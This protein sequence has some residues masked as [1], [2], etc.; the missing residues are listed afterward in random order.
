MNLDEWVNDVEGRVIGD[1]QCVALAQDYSTR[2]AQGGFLSTST[3]PYP[4]YAGNIW[5]SEIAGYTKRSPVSIA[6]PGWIVVWGRS[7][8]TPSTHVAIVL[9]DAGVGVNTMTQNPGAAKKM[10]IPKIGLLG[11]LAPN[12]SKSGPG[13]HLAGDDNVTTAVK[14][15]TGITQLKEWVSDSGNWQ[16]TGLY[17]LGFLLIVF[18]VIFLFKNDTMNLVKGAIK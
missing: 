12:N 1:G 4:G 9:N 10:V 18:A 14:V 2:V 5:T 11:Y 7:A 6:M 16:R 3:G 8:F 15:V 13:I 17:A